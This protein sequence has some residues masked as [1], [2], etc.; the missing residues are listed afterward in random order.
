MAQNEIFK[1]KK[2]TRFSWL[3]KNGYGKSNFKKKKKKT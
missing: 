3:A 2:K 1:K